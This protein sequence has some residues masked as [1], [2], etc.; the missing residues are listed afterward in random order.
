MEIGVLDG[1]LAH[2][3]RLEAAGKRGVLLD[4]LAVL[5]ERGGADGVQ[6][7]AR[8]GGLQD[9]ARV[10]GALGGAGAHDGVQLVDEQDDAAVGLLDLLEHALEAVLELAAVLGAGHERAHVKLHELLVLE[11]GGH[12]SGDD[13]L[14][15]ALDDGRLANARLADED[16]VVL[17]AARE[18]LDGAANLLHTPDD[19]VEFALARE[20]GHI[21]AVALEGLELGLGVLARHALVTAKVVVG[22]LDALARDARG[23]EDA[24]GVRAVVREGAQQVLARDVGVAELRGEL[25]GRVDDL[26]E[27]IREPHLLARAAHLGLAGDL[28]VHGAGDGARV[29]A[30][31]LDDG[32][33]VALAGVEQRL[34][35]VHRLDGARLGVRGNANGRLERLLGRYGHLV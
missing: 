3:H 5:V 8:Q 24:A 22:V 18:H 14:G 7:A 23:L 1:G 27:V 20:V 29:R 4:V 16:R 28:L 10:H 15:Q 26:H 6:L 35:Q 13:A 17:R 11:G 19:R 31:T 34:E 33:E 2:E 25:L 30:H 32:A 21:A 9:V 12:V